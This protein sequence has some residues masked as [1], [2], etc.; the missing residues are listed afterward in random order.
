MSGHP[1]V[2]VS[3]LD[4]LF[5]AAI[6]D[7]AADKVMLVRPVTII[8]MIAEIRQ[9]RAIDAREEFLCDVTYSAK[10]GR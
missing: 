10:V 6:D 7:Q 4:A 2:P 1:R 9:R 3:V 5:E 8:R